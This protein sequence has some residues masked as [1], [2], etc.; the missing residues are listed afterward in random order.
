MSLESLL[1]GLFEIA[2]FI[3]GLAL[4]LNL[5]RLALKELRKSLTN[6]KDLL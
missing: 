6:F 1:F 4:V 3:S 2:L 5:I